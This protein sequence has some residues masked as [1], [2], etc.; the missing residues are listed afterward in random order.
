VNDPNDDVAWN[1]ETALRN[2]ALYVL[3]PG[4][5]VPG[6][7]DWW[8]HRRTRIETTSGARESM[9]HAV[10][11]TEV[12]LPILAALFFEIDAG[13][14]AAMGATLVAHE[15][16]AM[17]DVAYATPRRA[18]A[19]REQ[20]THS[21]LEVLPFAAVAFAAALHPQQARALVGRGPE[22]AR[23][24]FR[25]KARPLSRRYIAGLLT[26]IAAC[27]V[28]PYG[29]ELLRCVRARPSLG[30]A[31]VPPRPPLAAAH[32]WVRATGAEGFEA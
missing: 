22:R 30:R 32:A 3:L 18:V 15:V 16:T 1:S 5:F 24:E 26:A 6:I 4:W 29:E 10:M 20:H 12:G 13:V 31:P 28:V 2:L 8:W 23:F 17:W 25:L 7:L 11:M 27:I 14:L 19:P 9:I 21:F